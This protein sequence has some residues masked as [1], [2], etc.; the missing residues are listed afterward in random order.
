M[1]T[2]A[3]DGLQVGR[4]ILVFKVGAKYIY[5]ASNSH[6]SYHIH[7]KIQTQCGMMDR[8][9]SKHLYFIIAIR[10]QRSVT[11]EP[12]PQMNEQFVENSFLVSNSIC[13]PILSL[14]FVS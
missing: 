14:F 4:W 3:I 6:S 10:L 1:T 8:Q 5:L 9:Q 13:F 11:R 12:V 7:S 2:C